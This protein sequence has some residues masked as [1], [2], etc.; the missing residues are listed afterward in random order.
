MK[1]IQTTEIKS[2]LKFL[3][4]KKIEKNIDENESELLNELFSILKQEEK[5]NIHVCNCKINPEKIEVEILNNKCF[6]CKLPII[7]E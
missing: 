2:F 3:Q 1:I 7:N 5:V 4:L 6:E